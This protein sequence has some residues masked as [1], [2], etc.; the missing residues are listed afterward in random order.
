LSDRIS[1]EHRT[2]C[3]SSGFRPESRI[4]ESKMMIRNQDHGSRIAVITGSSV[5]RVIRYSGN[6]IPERQPSQ[7]RTRFQLPSLE[8]SSFAQAWRSFDFGSDL[9]ITRVVPD[10]PPGSLGPAQPRKIEVMRTFTP[11]FAS[12]PGNSLKITAAINISG[13]AV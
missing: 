8:D 4:S 2:V 9:Q 3:C 12:P 7:L 10:F 1:P 6:C 11:D 13:L 5:G